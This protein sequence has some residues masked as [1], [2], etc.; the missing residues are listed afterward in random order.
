VEE[1][2]LQLFQKVY[3]WFLFC[4]ISL[5]FFLNACPFRWHFAFTCTNAFFYRHSVV[6]LSGME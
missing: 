1:P 4:M 5:F 2:G 6:N 3:E